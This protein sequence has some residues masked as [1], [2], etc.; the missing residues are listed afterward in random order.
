MAL[1][2]FSCLIRRSYMLISHNSQS[3][4]RGRVQWSMNFRLYLDK[5]KDWRKDRE[6]HI[7]LVGEA[8]PP[9][10]L[11]PPSS[12]SVYPNIVSSPVLSASPFL[13]PS[14]FRSSSLF[15]ALASTPF[16]SLAERWTR[17]ERVNAPSLTSEQSTNLSILPTYLP[18]Y[19]LIVTYSPPLK[20]L[21]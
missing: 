1:I 15:R 9:F 11:F 20:V 3:L 2:R 14:L 12:P 21:G 18:I 6:L 8:P 17:R 10:P 13:S 4:Y 19:L 7:P 5:F 16:L